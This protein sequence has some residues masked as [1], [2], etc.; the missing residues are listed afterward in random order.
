MT[1]LQSIFCY[2]FP[3]LLKLNLDKTSQKVTKD[4]KIQERGKK[5]HETYMKRL[6]E[7][8]LEDNQLPTPS[9]MGNSTPTPPPPLVP[10]LL[11]LPLQVT[12]CLLPLHMPQ[13]QMILISMALVYLLY[14]PMVFVYFLHITLLRLKIKKP[15]NE[16]QE[17][18]PKWL[19]VFKRPI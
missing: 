16:K 7:Q 14:L 18:S 3:F 4:P 9:P 11:L 19:Y 15:V 8:I 17:Q 13:G 1:I 10:H 6:K 2:P 5:L 12:L